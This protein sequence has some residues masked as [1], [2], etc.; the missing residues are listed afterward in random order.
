M[1]ICV[2]FMLALFPSGT[3]A[4]RAWRLELG[5]VA[6]IA[7]VCIPPYDVSIRRAACV[8]CHDRNA[9]RS[10]SPF[11]HNC[12][13]VCPEAGSVTRCGDWVGGR[14]G[15]DRFDRVA[16]N[17][18]GSNSAV[19]VALI[20]AAMLSYGF[21]LSIARSLQ[22][23]YGA[24]PVN[25]RRQG[26]ALLL[27][28]PLG[29]PELMNAHWTVGPLL[30]ML[31]LGMFGTAVANVAM[32]SAAG[33]FWGGAGIEHDFPHTGRRVAA[34]RAYTRRACRTDINDRMSRVSDGAPGRRNAPVATK[35]TDSHVGPTRVA[36]VFR[37]L[38]GESLLQVGFLSAY[39]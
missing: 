10:Q 17:E 35:V 7:L 38:C 24:I 32:A 18:R 12:R 16:G 36:S 19:G 6:W 31:A 23:K 25:P 28:A 26:V 21:A 13:L 8:V 14:R 2:G 29:L 39:S 5:G 9:E 20:M 34:R 1:R 30:C 15:R 37:V 4:G 11:C 3:K 33:R 22:Q 27:T